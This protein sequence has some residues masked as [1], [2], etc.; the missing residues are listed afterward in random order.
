MDFDFTESQNIM[1]SSAKKFL[2]REAKDI[3]RD[4]EK[5]DE[6][7]SLDLWQKMAELGWMGIVFPEQYG[8]IDGNFLDLVLIIEE[9]GK[10]LVSGPFIS[11]IISGLS[12]LKYG[13]QSQ[14]DEL[15][16]KLTEGKLIISH[17]LIEPDAKIVENKIEEKVTEKNGNYILNG[18]RLFA[19]YA[20][21]SD[22]IIYAANTKKGMTL[23]LIDT[24]GSGITTTALDTL[25]SDKLSEFTLEEKEVSN[26]N[27]LGVPG[28]GDEIINEINQ[29]GS[30]SV[31]AYIKGMLDEVLKMTVEHAKTRE[32]FGKKIGTL[33]AIQHQCSNMATDID[34]VKFLTYQAAWKLSEKLP[35]TKEI[36][37][38]K[39]WASDASRRTCLMGIKIHGGIG[40]SEEYNI[41]IYFRRAKS[42]E[43][44]HGDG[45][46]H[47]EIIA[48]EVGL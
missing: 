23:F 3:I 45:D 48:R 24:K 21:K 42:C 35:A 10:Y 30:L 33:Q 36:S 25:A 40:V 19:P 8:G 2:E 31:S 39:A 41:Q 7:F 44:S 38:A 5:T 26:K 27:I 14:R 47:R 4:V 37:M 16:P 9:M 17:A 28:K 15:L 6:G 43:L 34:Q 20:H 32:Q 1:L 29:W 22:L 13:T 12:I 18:T 11:T 46:Y